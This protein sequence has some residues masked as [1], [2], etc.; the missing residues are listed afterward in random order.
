M[1][2]VWVAALALVGLSLVG[3][4]LLVRRQREMLLEAE[5]QR[6]EGLAR[7][8]AGLAHQLRTPLATIKGTS[9][10]LLEE[11]GEARGEEHGRTALGRIVEQSERMERLLRDLLDYARPTGAEPGTVPLVEMAPELEALDPRV[12]VRFEGDPAVEADPEHLRQILANL[13]ENALAAAGDPVQVTARIDRSPRVP[14]SAQGALEIAVA[15]RGPGPGDDPERLFEP[16]VTERADGTGLGLPIARALAR[17]NG[18]EVTLEARP[19]GGTV[20]RLRLPRP[21][22]E[23]RP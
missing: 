7:A 10:L 8:G 2:V 4:R 1:P 11:R 15:D 17:A 22:T 3:G 5:R 12:H 19:G 21:S 18:G 9:Q 20:A 13:V 16:Y 6:L 14:G 23:D